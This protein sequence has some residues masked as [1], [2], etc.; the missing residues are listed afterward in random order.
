MS[1]CAAAPLPQSYAYFGASHIT[2]G[3]FLGDYSD[4]SNL[5]ALRARNIC[6][7]LNVASECPVSKE[8]EKNLLTMHVRLDD[9]SDENIS[10]HFDECL[11]FIRQGIERGEGVLVHC[12]MGISR[13]ATIVLAYLMKYGLNGDEAFAESPLS[14]PVSYQTV[15]QFLKSRRPEVNPNFGF[16]LAL[17]S[18]DVDRGLRSDIWADEE[19]ELHREAASQAVLVA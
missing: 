3:L 8:V 10:L 12:R 2:S 17:R 11:A 14:L 4:A 9:H 13:S 6:R 7:V 5:D 16:C 1:S 15:F 18:L 19:E